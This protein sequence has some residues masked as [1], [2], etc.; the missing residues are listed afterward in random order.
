MERL[1]SGGDHQITPR[2]RVVFAAVFDTVKVAGRAIHVLEV[3]SGQRFTSRHR[4][5]V[6]DASGA[7]VQLEA[8]LL[9]GSIV[10]VQY[11]PCSR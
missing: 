4:P 2:C 6:F 7:T 11:D 9:A 1:P 8:E 3:D 10:R 5:T